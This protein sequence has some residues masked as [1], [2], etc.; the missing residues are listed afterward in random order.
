MITRIKV[1]NFGYVRQKF[2]FCNDTGSSAPP[3]PKTLVGHTTPT[4]AALR[5]G[6]FILGRAAALSPVRHGFCPRPC[7][8]TDRAPAG[9]KLNNP[10]R[11]EA[12]PGGCVSLELTAPAGPNSHRQIDSNTSGEHSQL[13]Q[14]STRA[15]LL[16]PFDFWSSYVKIPRIKK[17]R[18]M[19]YSEIA[20]CGMAIQQ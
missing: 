11:S 4:V 2:C 20:S 14:L 17:V 16:R 15:L 1:K 3:G 7:S 9:P 18:D 5:L 10:R 12:T 6:L 19:S 8:A 13:N